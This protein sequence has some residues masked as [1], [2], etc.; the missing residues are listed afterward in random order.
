MGEMLRARRASELGEAGEKAKIDERGM[1][2]MNKWSKIS[3]N[4]D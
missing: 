2:K 1:G 4:E 3:K